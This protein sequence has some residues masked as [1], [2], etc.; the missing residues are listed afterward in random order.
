MKKAGKHTYST[1]TYV[2]NIQAENIMTGA[3]NGKNTIKRPTQSVRPTLN[4]LGK[5]SNHKNSHSTLNRMKKV[6]KSK[7][8]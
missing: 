1:H 2:P 7:I 3:N 6:L 8:H 5:K 4:N